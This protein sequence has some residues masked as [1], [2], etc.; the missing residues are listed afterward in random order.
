MR[1]RSEQRPKLSFELCLQ[2]AFSQEGFSGS[3]PQIPGNGSRS[4]PLFS[5][6]LLFFAGKRPDLCRWN[7]ICTRDIYVYIRRDSSL[8]KYCMERYEKG[9]IRIYTYSGLTLEQDD[10]QNVGRR[11]PE[12]QTGRESGS[13]ILGT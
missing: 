2:T 4:D 12:S 8:A 6:I 3:T 1:E 11:E 13:E 7:R 10:Q 5:P 9:N